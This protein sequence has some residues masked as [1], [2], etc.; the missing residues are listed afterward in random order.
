VVAT[1]NNAYLH[2]ASRTSL[3]REEGQALVE[4]ALILAMICVVTIAVL[5]AL[6]VDVSKILDKVSTSLS[7][8]AG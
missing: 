2:L 5:Q 4:Y 8:I 6:G 1:L 3:V 7:S